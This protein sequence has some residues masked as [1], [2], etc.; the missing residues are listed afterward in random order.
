MWAT[1]IA[2]SPDFQCWKAGRNLGT[3]HKATNI[4]TVTKTS[5]CLLSLQVSII[6][7]LGDIMS[8]SRI[9]SGGGVKNK[10]RFHIGPQGSF[11]FQDFHV[12]SS[13]SP[14]RQ[15]AHLPQRR[16]EATD[17]L[18]PPRVLRLTVG[19]GI[20]TPGHGVDAGTSG[21]SSFCWSTWYCDLQVACQ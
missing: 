4:C 14:H 21:K 18:T 10:F 19:C 2:S 13:P 16:Q 7:W 15:A 3:V 1:E 9:S 12:W 5:F 6:L 20:S 11:Q 8:N 17:S